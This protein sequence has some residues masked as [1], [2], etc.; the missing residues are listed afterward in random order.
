MEP[1]SIL[2][3]DQIKNW[4]HEMGIDDPDFF[5]DYPTKLETQEDWIFDKGSA[6]CEQFSKITETLSDMM[7]RSPDKKGP[8]IKKNVTAFLRI[9][10]YRNIS[11]SFRLLSILHKIQPSLTVKHMPDQ[12]GQSHST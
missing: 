9:L 1:S 6:C 4:I 10:A 8:I 3:S 5:Y 11:A 7:D 2:D 12:P